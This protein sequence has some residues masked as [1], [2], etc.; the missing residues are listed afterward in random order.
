MP[1]HTPTPILVL[2]EPHTAIV[3]EDN[4]AAAELEAEAEE[5]VSVIR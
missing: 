1:I 3:A 2:T 4:S 5:E